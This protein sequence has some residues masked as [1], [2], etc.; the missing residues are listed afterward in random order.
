MSEELELPEKIITTLKVVSES[1]AIPL[2]FFT[3]ATLKVLHNLPN[4]DPFLPS[5]ETRISYASKVAVLRVIVGWH[6]LKT[7]EGKIG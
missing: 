4:K 7:R 1:T 6:D 2:L 3:D 5:E